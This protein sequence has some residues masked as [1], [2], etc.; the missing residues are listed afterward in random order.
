MKRSN[1]FSAFGITL[2][3]LLL[4]S[5]TAQAVVM[6]WVPVGNAVLSPTT[7]LSVSLR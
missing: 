3:L 5:G 6:T 1:N 4:L 7:T 2:A